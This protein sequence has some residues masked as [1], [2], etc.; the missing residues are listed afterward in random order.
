MSITKF[1][2]IVCD[3]CEA[4]VDKGNIDKGESGWSY[5]HRGSVIPFGPVCC[6][7]EPEV[8]HSCSKELCKARLYVWARS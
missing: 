5:A 4:S 3:F 7:G 6:L 1:N 8:K 2:Q